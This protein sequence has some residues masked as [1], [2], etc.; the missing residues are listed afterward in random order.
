MWIWLRTADNCGGNQSK[1]GGF[2]VSIFGLFIYRRY[3]FA[4]ADLLKWLTPF[5]DKTSGFMKLRAISVSW[6]SYL[7]R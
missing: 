1:R 7:R 2:F 3:A 5:V 6:D 4:A